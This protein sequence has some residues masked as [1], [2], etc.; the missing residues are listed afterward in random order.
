VLG[1][2]EVVGADGTVVLLAPMH[3]RLLVAL[4]VERDATRGADALIDA[5]WASAPPRSAPKL[6]QVYVSNLRRVLPGSIRI[7]TRVDGYAL[8]FRDELLD[9]VRF[10][11]LVADARTARHER[12]PALAASLL[13]RALELWHGDAYGD[14]RY[15]DFAR[16][17]AERLEDLRVA[18]L[19]ERVEASLELGRHAESLPEALGLAKA[20]PFRERLQA[21]AMLALYRCGDQAGALDLYRSAR[22][23]L[24]DGLGLEP[25]TELRLLQQRILQ[26]D[27]A[28]APPAR[29]VEAATRVAALPD[30]F[31]GR[32]ADLAALRALFRR[33]DVR[34]IVLTGA[35]GSGKTRLALEAAAREAGSFAN[36]VAV[37]R[38]AGIR[39]PGFVVAAIA[40]GLGI[41]GEGDPLESLI[42]AL[43]P[44]ELLLVLDNAEQ[45]RAGTGV[46]VEIVQR[47]PRV[48]ILVTSRFVLHLSGE[49]VYPVDPLDTDSAAEL[50]LDRARA[51]DARFRLDGADRAVIRRICERLDGLPLAIEL[52]AA[53]VRT[54]ALGELV[55]RLD[56]RL[57]LLTGGPRD[58][59]AR[60]R[61]LRETIAWSFDLLDPHARRDGAR[62]SVFAGGFTLDAAEAVTGATLE[63]VSSLVD[64]NVVQ[65]VVTATGSRYTMLE[66]VREFAAEQLAVRGESDHFHRRHFEHALG[67]ARPLGLSAEAVGSGVVQRHDIALAEQDNMR[68]GLDWAADNEPQ[69]GLE[70]ALA[71]EQFWIASSP[72]EGARRLRH[73][74][75]R[76]GAVPPELRARALRDLGAAAAVTGDSDGAERACDESLELFERLGDEPNIVRLKSRLGNLA[77]A[78]GSRTR[79]RTLLEE[80]RGRARHG[81]YRFEESNCLGGLSCLECLEG[82]AE[83]AFEI[84]IEALDIVREHGGWP[85]GEAVHLANAAE[86]C[87]QLGRLD[88]A[89]AFGREAVAVSCTIGDR[90]AITWE[91]AI[92]ALCARARGDEEAAGRLWGAIEAEEESGFVGR[93]A[94]VRG[95]YA[96][97]LLE[98]ATPAFERGRN[99]GRW[100]GVDGVVARIVDAAPSVTAGGTGRAR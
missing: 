23:A 12:N 5:L 46:L 92:L 91:L 21:Q 96:H 95:D 19:E 73:L 55:D 89:E 100:L 35:G 15:E 65:R 14:L 53:R 50:F 25:G 86:S 93:F 26:Q 67:I 9:A 68:A 69:L 80:T 47:A 49:H 98:G 97:E 99:E 51:A 48:K 52:A 17:D 7:T 77:L 87:C 71:L 81:G 29:P 34:L 79:A 57:P 54:L 20:H 8:E 64:H 42:T 2:V 24:V 61:T 76:A 44:R 10:E 6:L 84:A 90:V 60:Q 72:S 1:P 39:D 63:S 94:S 38:L 27:P 3:R 40:D 82:R 45:L 58:L 30:S 78:R 33:D 16:F 32:A 18:A 22:A 4:L 43:M 56:A 59:P 36:G 83:L 70:L 62:F 13:D 66:T 88:E 75:A 37:V 74:L 11:R 28:L 41:H 31:V 85:W